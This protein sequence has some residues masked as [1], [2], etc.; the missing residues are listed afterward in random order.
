MLNANFYA[1]KAARK[2]VEQYRNSNARLYQEYRGT[3]RILQLAV[4]Q[5]WILDSY[6]DGK[7]GFYMY[8]TKENGSFL[9]LPFYEYTEMLVCKAFFHAFF[10]AKNLNN[11]CF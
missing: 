10:A 3:Y 8:F 2:V 9:K 7:E 6:G 4:K 1:L 5:G 11:L